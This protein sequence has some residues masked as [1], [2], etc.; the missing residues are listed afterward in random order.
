MN[1]L[2]P[3]IQH[4]NTAYQRTM[5]HGLDERG[6]M[7]QAIQMLISQLYLAQDA[8]LQRRFDAMSR[9]N[10]KTIKILMALRD[11]LEDGGALA[12]PEAHDSARYLIHAYTQLLHRLP[13]V[14]LCPKP[15]QEYQELIALLVPIYHGW[16][17]TQDA[18]EYVE[19]PS[20]KQAE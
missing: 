19:D 9:T 18:S 20:L 6:L 13:N 1:K 4:A 5:M 8:C 7:T 16:K 15:M 17:G 3:A 14:L 11:Q 2:Y 12:A 10:E